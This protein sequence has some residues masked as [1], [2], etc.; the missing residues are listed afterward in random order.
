[1]QREYYADLR[2]MRPFWEAGKEEFVN[3]L[4][5]RFEERGT[6]VRMYFDSSGTT[7]QAMES[8]D[9][10]YGALWNEWNSS[11]SSGSIKRA[12]D[13]VLYRQPAIGRLLLKWEYRRDLPSFERRRR[14]VMTGPAKF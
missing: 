10:F 4:I 3:D 2:G 13:L 9:D 11:R 1:M 14:F 12:R 7:Q 5:R 8:G 6:D